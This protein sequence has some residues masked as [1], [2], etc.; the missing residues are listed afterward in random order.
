M[1]DIAK[2]LGISV[3]AVS[4]AFGNKYGV[5]EGLR[6]KVILKAIE[7][8]Y[9]DVDARV[10][11]HHRKITLFINSRKD[12]NSNFWS[13]IIKGLEYAVSTNNI[14]IFFNILFWHDGLDSGDIITSLY[15]SKPN[16]IIIL[17]SC[18]FDIIEQLGNM[19]IPIVLIDFKTH[20]P[21][22]YDHVR[23]KNEKA[24]YRATE[25]LVGNGHRRLMFVGNTSFSLSFNERF[26]GFKQFIDNSNIPDLFYC[27]ATNTPDYKGDDEDLMIYDRAQFKNL[28]TKHRPTAVLCI[29]DPTAQFVYGQLAELNLK[30]PDDISVVSFDNTK[31]CEKMLPRLTSISI[32][33]TE[34][35]RIAIELLLE[36][37]NNPIGAR[38]T[39]LVNTAL[40]ERDSVKKIENLSRECGKD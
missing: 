39:V 32:P 6:S 7:M 35:G 10:P 26:I 34:I 24:F 17:N 25:Y 40:V 9:K 27:A 11:K 16:G 5:S 23:Y 19:T 4:L 33:Y 22:D 21:V 1:T 36:R 15:L 8:G 20:T 38:K 31:I 29:N 28:V 37:I 13:E 18:P 14:P 2:A 3:G 30:I 12:L